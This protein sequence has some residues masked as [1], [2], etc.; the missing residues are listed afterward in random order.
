MTS[1][2]PVI[3]PVPATCPTFVSGTGVSYG[4]LTGIALTVGPKSQGTGPLVF[5]WHGT[6]SSA[7][8]YT[9]MGAAVVN[10]IKAQGGIIVSPQ[11]GT[12]TGGDC[13]GTAIFSKDDFKAADQIVACAVRDYGIDPHRIYATGCSAG[14]LQS[15]CMAE[16]RSGY[17]AAAATNSG[18]IVIANPFKTQATYR[19]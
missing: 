18:G 6:G 12:G 9:L 1:K 3:P 14:G 16:L 7:G 17:I 4:G 19:R 15:G 10:E 8:E 11:A 5:Y 2:N 13:S